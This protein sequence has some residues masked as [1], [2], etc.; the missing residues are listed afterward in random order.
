MKRYIYLFSLVISLAGLNSCSK[1]SDPAPDPVVVGKWASDYLLTSG[2][3]APYTSSNALK[4]NP[5]VYGIND[6]Y[7]I[8]SDKTFV[9]TD[10]STSVIQTFPGTWDYSG[11][12]LNLKYNDGNTETLTYD[13][14]TTPAH[15]SFAPVAVQDT[16]QNPTTKVKEVVKFNLQLVYTKQ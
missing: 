5:L 6:V 11:T 16:L 10:R 2:F 7:D 8:K 14:S 4:L 15:L 13:A 1:S 12:Q 3:V 9:V